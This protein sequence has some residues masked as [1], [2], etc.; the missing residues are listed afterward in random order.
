MPAKMP[1]STQA[2]PPMLSPFSMLGGMSVCASTAKL[3]GAV[4][5]RSVNSFLMSPE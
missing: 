4:S 2:S 3:P 5:R 1:T